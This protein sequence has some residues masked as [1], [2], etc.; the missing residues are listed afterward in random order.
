MQQ[1]KYITGWAID[2]SCYISTKYRK[3]ADFDPSWSQNPLSNFNEAWQVG[4]VHYVWYPPHDKFGGESTTWVV[5]IHGTCHVSR[6]YFYPLLLSL[7]VLRSHFLT[8]LNDLILTIVMPRCISSQERAFWGLNNIR[9]CL[10]SNQN[11]Q[12]VFKIIYLKN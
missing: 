7:H 1:C 3:K 9:L 2:L 12:N 10:G 6:V 5:W 8:N 11:W 4:M